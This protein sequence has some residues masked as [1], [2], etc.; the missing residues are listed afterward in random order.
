MTKSGQVAGCIEGVP[1]LQHAKVAPLVFALVVKSVVFQ[2][3]AA[4]LAS[5]LLGM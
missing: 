1:A 4:K 3:A 5:T 2:T